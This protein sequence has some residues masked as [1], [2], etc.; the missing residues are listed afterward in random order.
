MIYKPRRGLKTFFVLSESRYGRS[1]CRL[2]AVNLAN[3]ALIDGLWLRIGRGPC[4]ARLSLS[5]WDQAK[6]GSVEYSPLSNCLSHI[7]DG[8]CA[9]RM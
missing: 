4:N 8:I 6:A 1:L 5:P 3:A 7:L 9:F 2:R